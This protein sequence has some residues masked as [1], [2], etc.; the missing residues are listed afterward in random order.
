MSRRTLLTGGG[1][2]AP[3]IV[4]PPGPSTPATRVLHVADWAGNLGPPNPSTGTRTGQT[5]H[6]ARL[7]A[8]NL[9]LVYGVGQSP[10]STIAVRVKVNSGA[11]VPVTWGGASS[12][13]FTTDYD[14]KT[15][16]PIA[17]TV[18]PGDTITI[19]A[20]YTG[21]SQ[22]FGGSNRSGTNGTNEGL[23]SGDVLTG[24]W[25]TSG[26]TAGAPCPNLILGDVALE[27]PRT[28]LQ[29]GDSIVTLGFL[30][31]ALS[32]R[33]WISFAVYGEALTAYGSG[34]WLERYGPTPYGYATHAIVEYGTNDLG[35]PYSGGATPDAATVLANYKSR[36]VDWWLT[37]ANSGI[38]VYQTT[39]TPG[40]TSTDGFAT[41]ANQT[42]QAY[43][44]VRVPAN[45]WFRDGAPLAGLA[46]AAT[47]TTDPTAIR[48][49]QPGHPLKGVIEVA[50]S[51]E[52]AR[53]SG[54]WKS[55]GYT[56]DGSHP[57]ALGT[58]TMA[59]A[60]SSWLTANGL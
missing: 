40:T 57:T 17:V 44:V 9:R 47:G 11:F 10:S 49:G 46:P 21:T 34:S 38:K 8:T 45:D 5:I 19:R 36:V 52:T 25:P 42:A 1:N 15:S 32:G 29:S 59:D 41:T 54:K 26:V 48:A 60:V 35:Q 58:T 13:S 31:Q 56:Y 24:T 23:V 27:T 55:P 39:L 12:A 16:D 51:V 37:L 28:W 22:T 18:T 4:D 50:D 7:A 33:A 6:T 53:N 30:D 43:N 14:R 3:V 20:L 2:T